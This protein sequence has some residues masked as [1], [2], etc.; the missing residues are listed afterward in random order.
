LRTLDLKLVV[1]RNF[2]AND[3]V[4][5]HGAGVTGGPAASGVIVTRALA[6]QL[7]HGGS[8]LGQ[9][10]TM[11]PTR[12]SAPIVGIIDKLQVP[13]IALA[14]GPGAERVALLPYRDLNASSFYVVRA[15]PGQL[16]AVSI[17]ARDKLL[18]ISHDRIIDKVQPLSEARRDA[19]HSVRVPAAMLAAISASLLAVTS[20]G[21]VGL[22][23]FWV[24]QRRRQI[25]IRRTLGAT[26]GA[27]MRYFQIE[28][29]LITATGASAGAALAV[30]ANL[31]MVS[32]FSMQRL[33]IG[34]L[35]TGVIVMLVL[36]QLAVLWPALRAA[37]VPPAVATRGM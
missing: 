9:T 25:G 14:A 29:L 8:A 11:L 3:V 10:L 36:G 7:A 19:Y 6:G 28:S 2:D 24:V 31:W 37:S 4:D 30:T 18:A 17:A 15:R 16:R 13:W 32:T 12:Q 5:Y 21:I 22:A 20:F 33:P 23:S 34:Y 27:I 26:R 35:V 1:G